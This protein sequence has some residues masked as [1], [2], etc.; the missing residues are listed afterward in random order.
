MTTLA[1]RESERAALSAQPLDYRPD[2]DGLRAVA[3]LAVV[4]F[5]AFPQ[6][7][8]GGFVG[9]DVFFVISGFLIS[10]IILKAHA[11]NTFSYA[12][13]YARRIRRIFPA[14]MLM[15]AASLVFGWFALTP[16][17]FAELGRHAAAGTLFVSNLALWR[18]AGYFDHEA[19]LKPLLHLWSLGIE[20]QFYLI[21]PLFLLRFRRA[22]AALVAVV[23]LSFA[24]NVWLVHSKPDAT[25][26]MPFTRFWE[27][28][29]GALL[30]QLALMAPNGDALGGLRRFAP[31]L[32]DSRALRDAL[33]VA[34]T[35]LVLAPVLRLSHTASFPGFWAA[36]PVLGTVA[37]IAA[38]QRAIINRRLLSAPPM[39]LIGLISYPL[40]LW[41][42]PL[43]VD[44]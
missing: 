16:N 27:L 14:L 43:L 39:V 11:Q 5:H 1:E 32:G 35:L 36:L 8:P 33:S 19:Q 2:I 37:L 23:V 22:T 12:R 10:T 29:S 15:L 17:E 41:H 24:A 30:A 4:S 42:W 25:F 34:G 31:F 7:T 3:V 38:G 13:F 40:Y 6:L 44:P 20:E 21:W 28:A 26:Y 9:V 18:E